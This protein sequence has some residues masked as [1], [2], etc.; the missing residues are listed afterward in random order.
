MGRVR[1]RFLHLGRRETDAED[2]RGLATPGERV[3]TQTHGDYRHWGWP[4]SWDE[5]VYFAREKL[6]GLVQV[7]LVG[8]TKPL[9][10]NALLLDPL[11][12]E[13]R[14]VREKMPQLQHVQRCFEANLAAL[15]RD[16][17]KFHPLSP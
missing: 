11:W 4:V 17:R 12:H 6:G 9:P 10:T 7:L 13:T 16:D 2:C 14:R 8:R 15:K 5:V 3:L 1:R